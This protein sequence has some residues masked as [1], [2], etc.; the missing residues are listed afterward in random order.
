VSVAFNPEGKSLLTG[1]KDG[2]VRRWPVPPPV[3]GDAGRIALWTRV[4]S[5]LE[6]D[7][8]GTVHPLDAPAWQRA[9]QRLDEEGGPPMP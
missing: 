2:I 1:C 8:N 6:M 4:L 7:A 3:E 9:K 5:G